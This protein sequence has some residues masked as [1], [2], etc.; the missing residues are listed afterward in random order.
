MAVAVGLVL[1]G[2]PLGIE[3]E[4]PVS[5]GHFERSLRAQKRRASTSSRIE[6]VYGFTG[7]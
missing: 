4:E 1:L 2:W 7:E 3:E 5:D 6:C